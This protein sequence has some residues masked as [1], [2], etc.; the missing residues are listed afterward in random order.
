MTRANERNKMN[1]TFMEKERIQACVQ[2]AINKIEE[3]KC[4]SVLSTKNFFLLTFSSTM[5]MPAIDYDLQ[6]KTEY[7]RIQNIFLKDR[8]VSS[9]AIF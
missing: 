8:A 3:K 6:N 7:S 5:I 2:R 1:R 9:H 4:E